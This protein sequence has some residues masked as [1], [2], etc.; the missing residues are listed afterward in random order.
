M[1]LDDAL[2]LFDLPLKH[3]DLVIFALYCND[4]VLLIALIGRFPLV[5]EVLIFKLKLLELLF[6]LL[7]DLTEHSAVFLLLSQ[8]AL[9]HGQLVQL[10]GHLFTFL[11]HTLLHHLLGDTVVIGLIAKLGPQLIDLA[12]QATVLFEQMV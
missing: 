12:H 10:F 5:H 2:Q 6:L 9:D 1:R 8:L 3:L 7:C 11:A 4:P